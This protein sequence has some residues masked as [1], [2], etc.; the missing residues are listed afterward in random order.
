MSF[1]LIIA[2]LDGATQGSWKGT[3]L[4]ISLVAL[5]AAVVWLRERFKRANEWIDLTL[6][7]NEV[8]IHMGQQA[9]T[10]NAVD[11][12]SGTDRLLADLH[13]MEDSSE[14]GETP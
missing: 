12:R 13:D 3:L 8:T 1:D 5:V 4:V 10:G 9:V 6:W 7:D 14:A 11:L 2:F